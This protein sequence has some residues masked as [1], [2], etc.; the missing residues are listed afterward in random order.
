MTAPVSANGLSTAVPDVAE[1]RIVHKRK[2]P[3]V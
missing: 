3:I 2:R 1:L